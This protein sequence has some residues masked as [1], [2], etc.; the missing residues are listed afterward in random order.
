MIPLVDGFNLV[1][2]SSRQR[3]PP[4]LFVGQENVLESIELIYRVFFHKDQ[5]LSDGWGDLQIPGPSFVQGRGEPPGQGHIGGIGVV[6][7]GDDCASDC[8][9]WNVREEL[10]ERFVEFVRVR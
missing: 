3:G 1:L 5:L 7:L 10:T 2:L 6:L 8:I 4:L 9:F